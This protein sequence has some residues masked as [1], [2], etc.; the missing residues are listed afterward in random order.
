[1]RL[2]LLSVVLV[3]LAT[4]LSAGQPANPERAAE[5]QAGAPAPAAAA[6]RA[7][8]S[9]P[10]LRGLIEPL[11]PPGSSVEVLIPPGV[12]EHGYE[13]PPAKLA[14]LARA[15]LV[16]H[17][18]LGLEP[19]VLKF[20]AGNPR[21]AR[22]VV[23]AA[24]IPAVAARSKTITPHVC[25]GDHD[26]D[27]HTLAAD[28]HL[29]LDPQMAR[30]LVQ[31]VAAELARQA[32]SPRLAAAAESLVQRIDLIDAR[33][34]R[35]IRQAAQKTIVVAHDAYGWLA[36]RYDLDVVAIAGLAGGEPKPDDIR[37]AI[38]AVREQRVAVV[39]AEPQLNPAAARRVAQGAGVRLGMLD[40]L[41]DGDWFKLME[42]NL[43]ALRDGLGV[44]PEVEPA[45]TGG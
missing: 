13:I 22:L 2:P 39:F 26:H 34:A 10:P 41:G 33:Y 36:A 4:A 28:P 16:V 20:L 17:V 21:P 35:A 5:A 15:D 42:T 25:E 43:A 31:H 23:E 37:D 27:A 12:S 44:G 8:V 3:G 24:S 32:P 40:P 29:W 18:G 19:Q 1:M 45:P 9:I 14:A 30:A 11:L 6:V 7:V 38:R